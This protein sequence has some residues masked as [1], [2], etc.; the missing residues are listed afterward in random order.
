MYV[1]IIFVKLSLKKLVMKKNL[2]IN[3]K[4][5]SMKK[6]AASRYFTRF[7]SIESNKRS[8]LLIISKYQINNRSKYQKSI[9]R[10][11]RTSGSR[12]TAKGEI[13]TVTPAGIV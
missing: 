12:A 7:K 10:L 1:T 11:D 6:K 2:H 3:F 8:D 9:K 4:G 13:E 5:E